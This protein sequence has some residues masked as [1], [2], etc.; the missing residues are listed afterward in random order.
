MIDENKLSIPLI[1]KANAISETV[2]TTP[3]SENIIA[4]A[5]NPIVIIPKTA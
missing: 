1:I 5:P 2:K 3:N 4:D